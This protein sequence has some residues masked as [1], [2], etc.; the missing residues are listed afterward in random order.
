MN[1]LRSRFLAALALC[2]ALLAASGC[3]NFPANKPSALKPPHNG[4]AEAP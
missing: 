1:L 2:A 4:P 3:A